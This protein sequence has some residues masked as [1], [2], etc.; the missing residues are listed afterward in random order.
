MCTVLLPPGGYA[1]AVNKYIIIITIITTKNTKRDTRLKLFAAE[2]LMTQ[3][4][5]DMD[6]RR[7]EIGSRAFRPN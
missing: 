2:G 6:T 3:F 5:W 4:F 7:W 1:T